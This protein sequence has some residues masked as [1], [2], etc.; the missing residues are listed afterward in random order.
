MA[1]R[2]F[3]NQGKLYSQHV[4]P[5][6]LDCTIQIG[7]SGAVSSFAGLGVSSVTRL[8]TGIYQILMQDNYYACYAI[9]ANMV[10]PQ[11]GSAIAGGSFSVGTL[12]QIVS[13]GTTTQAQWVAAGLPASLTAAPGLAFVATAVGAGT[14][15]VKAVG[16]SGISSVELCALPSLSANANV[17]VQPGAIFLL[18]TLAP[19]STSV[20]TSIPANPASGSSIVATFLLNNSSV[21]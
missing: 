1:N 7:A 4:M 9:D 18:Q 11:T 5:I 17:A 19:T 10:S 2:N 21:Q 20:T 12:Y 6:A 8:A 16:N 13:L 3:P 15:T 14:G